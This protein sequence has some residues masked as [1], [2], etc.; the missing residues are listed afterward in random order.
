MGTKIKL[1][2]IYHPQSNGGQEKFNKTLIEALRTY[3]SHRQDN[4]D[5]CILFFEFAYNNSGNPSTGHSP[6][7]LSYAQ[8]PRAPWQFLDDMLPDDVP[9]VDASH[10]TKLSGTQ[11]ASS[12]GLDIINNVRQARDTLHH[13]AN[14]FRVRNAYLAKPHSY[15]VGNAVLLSTKN[16]QLN[17]PCKKLSPTYVAPFTIKS[18]LGDNVVYLNV[19]DRFRLLNPHVNIA[20]LRSYRLRTPD[21]GPSPVCLSAKPV[22]VES[23]GRGWYQIEEILDHRGPATN[24]GECLVRWKDF[25]VSHSVTPLA[26]QAYEEFLTTHDEASRSLADRTHHKSD[27]TRA[28]GARKHLESFIGRAGVFSVLRRQSSNVDTSV[29][30]SV[31]DTSPSTSSPVATA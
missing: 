24:N 12:L 8:S 18:L 9:L 7:I 28:Q 1:T 22:S 16:V 23:D 11:M 3:V 13:M 29:Q 4:W 20:Y 30:T 10:P 17:L 2:S 15:K 14:E 26:L 25:D 19:T 27:I 6:F 21:I 31:R 5:E